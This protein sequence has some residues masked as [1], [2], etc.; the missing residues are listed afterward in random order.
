MKSIRFYAAVLLMFSSP[1]WANTMLDLYQCPTIGDARNCSNKC[2]PMQ[3]KLQKEIR[4]DPKAKE[5]V[6]VARKDGKVEGIN[7]LKNCTIVD[8]KNWVCPVENE[9]RPEKIQTTQYMRNGNYFLMVRFRGEI[10][11]YH[12]AK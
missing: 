2:S 1:G 6:V 12:C 8:S 10:M 11:N 3:G 9:D 5:V 4:V 7:G